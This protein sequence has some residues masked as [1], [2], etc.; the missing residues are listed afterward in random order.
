MPLRFLLLCSLA[1]LPLHAQKALDPFAAL[2]A[3][4][5][6]TPNISSG[7]AFLFDLEAKFARATAEGGGAAF[8]AWFAD[9]AVT[10]SNGK[11]PVTGHSAIAAQAT[12][13][14]KAYQLTWTPSGG[15]LAGDMGYTWG[16]YEGHSLG[17]DGQKSSTTGR[18]I[19]IWK[20]QPGGD[21]K[22]ELD[23]SNDEP[24]AA[25]ECCKLP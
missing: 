21:W 10:L 1:S 2:P 8:A 5:L 3:N 14:A 19:T 9:D 17:P 6:A 15:Q 16:H 22:V 23:A 4:Q 18:Y 12:W 11:A 13:S 24:A 7:T 25:G 20:K